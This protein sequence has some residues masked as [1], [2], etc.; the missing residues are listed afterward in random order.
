MR[1]KGNHP[2]PSPPLKGGEIEKLAEAN[3]EAEN[4]M[5]IAVFGTGYVGLTTGAC[6]AEL[7]HQVTCVDIDEARI[8]GLN[9][10]IVHFYEPGLEELVKR[11]HDAGTLSFTL[12]NAAAILENDI[13]FIAVGTPT[14]ADGSVDL[15]QVMTVAE[16]IGQGIDGYK[17]I[18]NKSTVPPGTGARVRSVI[19]GL[20]D[21]EFD[22][23][24]NPEFLKEGSA[25]NDFLQTDR[26]VIGA[27]TKKAAEIMQSLYE[28]LDCLVLVTDIVTAEIIKYA[29]NV[30]F[31]ASISYINFIAEVCER[32]GGDVTKVAEGMRLDK[33]IG[34]HAFLN[35]GLGYGGSCFPKDIKGLIQISKEAGADSSLLEAVEQIN[36]HQR[37]R[38]MDKV[39]SVLPVLKGK[40]IGMWGLAF[41]P[42]SDDIREAPAIDIAGR[43]LTEGAI[44]R[45][46]DPVAMQNAA[47]IFPGI[48]YC[49]TAMDAADGCDCLLVMTEWEE[50]K[51]SDLGE[52]KRRL[53][54]PQV[55]DGRN[56]FKPTEM[57]KTGFIY[58]SV[59]R[60][61]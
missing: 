46:Y 14:A 32:T 54:K 56:V 58:I 35:A 25:V 6:L 1:G 24:S 39:H 20:Y 45:A 34:P 44:I 16:T 57:R 60:D 43:L 53:N 11:N 10:K 47:R 49:E 51:Y 55:I 31:A 36:Q 30:Y 18:V 33:R 40:T 23:V 48:E 2:P 4:K 61:N 37:D 52:L 9:N 17:L 27:E 8:N 28:K 15:S 12:D 42:D 26:V 59:G 21:G 38:F 7:G 29:S 50:F 13:I 3:G 5:N 22:V 41:K 19:S